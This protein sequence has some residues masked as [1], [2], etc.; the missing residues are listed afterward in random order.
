MH[1]LIAIQN[2]A[3]SKET[4]WIALPTLTN[5]VVPM[6]KT[7]IEIT[8]SLA[9][10]IDLIDSPATQKRQGIPSARAHGKC[11]PSQI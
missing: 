6:Q 1:Q 5:N 4:K 7:V 3:S 9:A 8:T 11:P 2:Q 10:G